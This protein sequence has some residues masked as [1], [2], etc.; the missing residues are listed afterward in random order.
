MLHISGKMIMFKANKM[1]DDKTT[2]PTSRDA[3]VASRGWCEK[4]MRCHGFSLR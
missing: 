3:L 4:F 2:D 1:F